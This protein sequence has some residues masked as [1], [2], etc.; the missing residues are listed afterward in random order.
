MTGWWSRVAAP[1]P[2]P[3]V[4][5]LMGLPFVG[6]CVDMFLEPEPMPPDDPVMN[7]Q[8][9]WNEFDRHYSFFDQKGVDWDEAYDR[10]RPRVDAESS[11]RELFDAV[12]EMLAELRDGHVDLITPFA[13]HSYDGWREGRA[14][15]FDLRRVFQGYFAGTPRYASRGPFVYGRLQDGTGYVHISSFGGGGFGPGIDEALAALDG[16]TGLVVDIR[17][18]G[19]GSDLNLD[20]VVG[21]FADRK[22]LYRYVR[23]RDGP[24]HDDFTDF[25]ERHVEPRGSERYRGPVAVLTNRMNFSTA[26]DFVMAMSVLPDVVV[27]GDTTGGGM[28][29]PISRELPNGWLYRLSRWRVY[30]ADRNLIVD[31]EGIAP[32]VPLQLSPEDEADGRD[33]ILE[34]ALELLG[35]GGL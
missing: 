15:N 29:N 32:D 30:D 8:V 23:Y 27:V 3:G 24:E 6:G 9:L 33:T 12:S 1:G 10:Y 18:N 2:I 26:E 17:S 7:F 13:S 21:R 4:L 25:I 35:S 34:A 31:G 5:L 28:G 19:G 20:E 22:R 16:V 14:E 11:P